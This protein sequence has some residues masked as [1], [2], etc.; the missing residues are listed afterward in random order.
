MKKNRLPPLK[1]LHAFR[2]AA[3]SL[4]FKTAAEQLNVTQAAVSQQIKTLEQSL[5]LELFERHTRQVVLTSE[6][7]YLFT[8]VSQAFDL[9]EQGVKE[10][11]EDPNP[12]KLVISTLP[13]FASRWLVSRLGR[14]Q[15]QEQNI[16]IQLSPSLAIAS[17]QNQEL[18]LSIRFGQ[19][20]YEGLKSELLF[21]EEL[22]PI[23]HPSLI[24]MKK[25]I[26]PQLAKL[27]IIADNGPD[28]KAVW[29]LFHQIIGTEEPLTPSRLQVSDS[30]VLIEALLSCQGISMM[31]Y[32][33]V[34]ELIQKGQLISPLPLHMK[35]RYNFYLVAPAPH[36]KYEKMLKFKHWLKGE[37]K[38]IQASWKQYQKETKGLYEVDF[39]HISNLE[40]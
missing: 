32:S 17:F 9:L 2:Y 12:N 19:G 11:I 10:I 33:L 27:P 25:P 5:E 36:F 21:E 6:G 26:P 29:P 1:S 20:Q 8:Y 31:R 3:Q 37:V 15:A 24:D 7:E 23:C 38:E 13:S 40:D 39:N 18:D 34:Y 4:S 35:S 16:D 28:M 14:F 30:T 22:I